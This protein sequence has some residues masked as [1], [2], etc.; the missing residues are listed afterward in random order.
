MKTTLII[1]LTIIS[2]L[3]FGQNRYPVRLGDKYGFIDKNGEVKIQPTYDNESEFINGF[4]VLTQN[5]LTTI[6]IDTNGNRLIEFKDNFPFWITRKNDPSHSYKYFFNDNRLPVFD[7]LTRRYGF[8]DSK[9]NLVIKPQFTHIS[10]FREGRASVGFWDNNPN[11]TF[12]THSTEYYA[13][14]DS[15]KWGFIDTNGVL[16]IDTKYKEVSSFEL[17]VC[18]VDG[19]FI[20]KFGNQ[21]KVDTI[22]DP[23]LFCRLQKENRDFHY[24]LNGKYISP[25]SNFNDCGIEARE[26][27]DGISSSGNFGFVDCR[28]NWLIKPQFQNVRP[29]K[30]GFAGI[31]RKIAD[32]QF[33]WGF[34]DCKGDTVISFQYEQ[35]GSF[36]DNLVPVCKNKKWGI[37]NEKNEIIIPFEYDDKWPFVFYEFKDDLILLYKNDKQVYLNRKGQVIWTE[38]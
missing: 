3:T 33:D 17:G 14:R 37:V 34:I 22:S 20:D 31:Q 27:Y 36:S 35:V 19:K 11:R 4:A 8:I 5:D 2:I 38:K 29:F 6:V 10:N 9:G 24:Q 13:Y 7:T 16:V 15:V 30:N 12:A 18:K 21:I 1:L 25:N 26:F 28:N 23:R 32:G